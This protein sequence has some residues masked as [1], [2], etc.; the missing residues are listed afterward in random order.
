VLEQQER[1]GFDLLVIDAFSSDAI[2]THLLTNEAVALYVEHL[3]PDGVLAIHISNRYLDLAPVCLR[4]AEHVQKPA[5]IIRNERDDMSNA[6]TWV[7]LTSD[8][9]IFE[10]AQFAGVD[11]EVPTGDAKFRAWTDAYSSLWQVLQFRR[12]SH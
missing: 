12:D 10:E 3:K 6:S 9:S 5:T 11:L 8:T 2:P 1:Q 4:A 7:A